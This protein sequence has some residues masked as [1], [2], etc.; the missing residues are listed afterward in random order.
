MFGHV[1]DFEPKFQMTEENVVCFFLSG[2]KN[3]RTLQITPRTSNSHLV[4]GLNDKIIDC[5]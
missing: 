3:V 4:C 1:L 5:F 2:H